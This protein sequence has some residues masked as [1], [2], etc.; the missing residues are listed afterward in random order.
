MKSPCSLPQTGFREKAEESGGLD[1]YKINQF[2]KGGVN[3]S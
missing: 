2:R 1:T 3:G